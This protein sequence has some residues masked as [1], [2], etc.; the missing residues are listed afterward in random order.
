M[1]GM[2]LGMLTANSI[3]DTAIVQPSASLS[4]NEINRVKSILLLG[5]PASMKSGDLVNSKITQQD[6]NLALDYFSQTA[7]G[8]FKG[9][10][11]SHVKLDEKQAYVQLSIRLPETPAGKFLNISAEIAPVDV[12]KND[13]EAVIKFKALSIGNLEIATFIVDSL[14]G[15]LHKQMQKYIEE[16][17]LVSKT[18]HNISFNKHELNVNYIWDKQIANSIKIKLGSRLI[19]DNLKS[20]IIACANRLS[21]LNYK[22][23]SRPSLNELFKPMFKQAK[24]RSKINNPVTENKAVFIVMAANVLNRDIYRLI[25][26]G[27]NIKKKS[28]KFYLK[29]RADLSKHF[30]ISAAITSMADSNLAETIGF[31]KEVTDSQGRSGFSFKDLAADY[32]GIRLAEY[33]IANEQQARKVQD[34]LSS[35]EFETDYM[36]AIGDLPESLNRKEL[37]K[38]Y[39]KSVTYKTMEQLIKMRID[40]LMLYKER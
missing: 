22:S 29:G 9:R 21:H 10:I 31:E 27:G 18:I 19:S 33:A 1:F 38:D 40:D 5:N 35:I 17:N 30:L 13:D 39:M 15:F 2:L 3:E 6:L 24:E 26:N 20:A 4:V 32:A 23:G 12:T 36:P 14:G 8:A 16:Y 7:P 11:N 37:N 34:K 28:N 25:D